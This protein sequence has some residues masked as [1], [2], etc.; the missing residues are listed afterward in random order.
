[1]YWSFLKQENAT[2]KS[3]IG[4]NENFYL[5]ETEVHFSSISDIKVSLWS[6]WITGQVIN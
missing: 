1:M 6:F 2:I 3:I 4:I 5:T